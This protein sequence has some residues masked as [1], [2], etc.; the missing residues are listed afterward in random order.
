ME[1]SLENRRRQRASR[2]LVALMLVNGAFLLV[3]LLW[4][5]MMS[6]YMAEPV[7]WATWQALGPRPSMLDYP[8][9]L[10]WTLPLGAMCAAWL[11][12]QFGNMRMACGLAF[13]PVFYMSLIVGWFYVAP[14][15]WH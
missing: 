4:W 3:V 5:Q 14:P 7:R 6:I 2:F 15:T 13:F 9:V 8:F 11:A 12:R 1:L 10:L